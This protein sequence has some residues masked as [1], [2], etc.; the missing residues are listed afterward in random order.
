MSPPRLITGLILTLLSV[1]A[2]AAA[3]PQSV[4]RESFGT[5]RAG[6]A[7]D[8]YTLRN[9]HG[10]EVQVITYG[11][12]ITSLRTPDRAG[13]FD[14]IVLG[15]DRLADYEEKSPY[16]GAVVGRVANRVARGRFTLDGK[17]YTLA[18]N[19]GPNALHGGLKGFDKVIW[20][21]ESFKNDTSVGVVLTYTSKD[22]E[23]GYPGTLAVRVTYTLTQH[24]ALVVDYHA[25][26]D[27]ATPVNL[28]QHT[29]WNLA[30]TGPGRAPNAP[31]LDAG[32]HVLTIHATSY[33]PVDSTLIPTGEIA[34][35]AG[36]PFDFRTPTAIGARIGDRHQQLRFGGGYD[37]NLVLDRAVRDGKRTA[38][39]VEEPT[40]GRTLDIATTEPGVQFYSGNFL[41]GTLTGKAG[42]RYAY[43]GTVVLET[44]HYPDSPNHPG[45]PNTILRPGQTFRSR[46]VFT[47]GVKS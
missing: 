6:D 23:E 34:R 8:R 40:T 38:I 29:Y 39:R 46:T 11:A 4:T 41:D 35:V 17:E 36:T 20:R 1:R 28:S 42:R 33:T 12:I 21:A 26:T 19:N 43:R 16:F 25:T 18:V 31:L 45:F 37:H 32:A 10:V 47:F 9:A 5:T 27:K 15:F 44:Q 24:D 30:G 3:S 14:D 7:V 2:A 13:R 22:G